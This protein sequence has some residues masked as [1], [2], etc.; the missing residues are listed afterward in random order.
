[1][2]HQLYYI[3]ETICFKPHVFLASKSKDQL[4]WDVVVLT[5]ADEL[6]KAAFEKQLDIK[7][8]DHRIPLSAEYLVVADPPGYKIG[9]YFMTKNTV[10]L[11]LVYCH[12][13]KVT[14]TD[15]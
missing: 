14:S 5:A 11:I 12:L 3:A 8:A 6:Q 1:M 13:Q 2:N 15:G 9:Q 7:L 10:F 4:F